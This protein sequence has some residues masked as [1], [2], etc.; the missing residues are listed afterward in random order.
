MYRYKWLVI[1]PFP[2]ACNVSCFSNSS[3]LFIVVESTTMLMLTEF[4]FITMTTLTQM[5][6][7]LRCIKTINMVYFCH[8]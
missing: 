1:L 8:V 3:A 2:S 5:I 4:T 7:T 6:L